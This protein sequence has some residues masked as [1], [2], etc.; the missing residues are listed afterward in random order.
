MDRV[1]RSGRTVGWEGSGEV[2]EVRERQRDGITVGRREETIR[3]KRKGKE[4]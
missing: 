1:A 2:R 3:R 4:K